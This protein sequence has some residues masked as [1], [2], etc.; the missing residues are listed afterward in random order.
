MWGQNK[1]RQLV[2]SHLAG[3]LPRHV[4]IHDTAHV[5]HGKMI[6]THHAGSEVLILLVLS[7]P[8]HV[9]RSVRPRNPKDIGWHL[10]WCCIRY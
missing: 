10:T 7:H 4:P 6:W 8:L 3:H 1:R 5:T 9:L 2:Y